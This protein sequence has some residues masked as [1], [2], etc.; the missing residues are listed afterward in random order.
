MWALF[1]ISLLNG[2]ADDR[3]WAS[4]LRIDVGPANV[5][6][7]LS[8]VVLGLAVAVFR[9]G[10]YHAQWPVYRSHPLL[11]LLLGLFGV[12]AFGGLIATFLG[13]DGY[14]IF[15]GIAVRDFLA[16]PLCIFIGYRLIATPR[17]AARFPFAVI[18]TGIAVSICTITYFAARAETASIRGSLNY[19]RAVNFIADYPGITCAF[20]VYTL[21]SGVRLIHGPLA[22]G[23][24]GF[25]LVGQAA[26]LHRSNWLA[27]AVA[28]M[29]VYFLLPKARRGRAIVTGVL[30]TPVFLATLW[31]GLFFA[32]K[33]TNRDFFDKMYQ[34]VESMLPGERLGVQR[35]KAWDTRLASSLRELEIWLSSPIFG[36]GFAVQEGLIS[37]GDP[38]GFGF[39]HNAFTD[40][41]A[42]TGL[43]GF[44]AIVLVLG[45][46]M[47]IGRRMVFDGTDR[48]TVLVGALAFITAWF[49]VFH[50]L[51]T[52]SFNSFRPAVL[53]GFVCGAMI[54]CREM[55]LFAAEPAVEEELLLANHEA[56]AAAHDVVP[57]YGQRWPQ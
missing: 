52:W 23:I 16:L 24:A 46:C 28:I 11:P 48:G 4:A 36:A 33:A 43:I 30:V 5:N 15:V 25:C 49:Y 47:S 18:A 19:V 29:S 57:E 2:A 51:S 13:H 7:F 21:L 45:G 50:G 55:Q 1:L 20:L 40:T 27:C 9:G 38:L 39:H 34:R 14:N 12:A 17:S 6:L 44:T 53:L 42:K 31:A 8:L 41:L 37:R 26:P 22:V 56:W 10:A 35:T 3:G 54:R 32:S